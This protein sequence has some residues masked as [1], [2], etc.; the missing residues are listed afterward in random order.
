VFDAE[1]N[2]H[3]HADGFW[4]LAM[5]SDLLAQPDEVHVFTPRV[6]H[7]TPQLGGMRQRVGSHLW[8][9]GGR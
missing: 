8:V 3:G 1:R 6:T 9:P 2:A 4:S 5:L 7:Q